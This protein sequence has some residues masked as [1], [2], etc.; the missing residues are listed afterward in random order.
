MRIGLFG[1]TFNPVHIGHLRTVIEVKEQFSLNRIYIVPS[2]IP[3]HKSFAGIASPSDRIEM[4]RLSVC[5]DP[6]FEVSDV[7]LIRGGTS[8]T[9]DTLR[10]FTEKLSGKDESFFIMG[11]DAFLEIHTWKSFRDIFK[12]MPLI[13]MGRPGTNNRVSLDD[14][15]LAVTCYLSFHHLSGYEYIHEHF[16][17]IHPQ[18]QSVYLMGVTPIDISSSKI[19]DLASK[20]RSIRFL[21]PEAVFQ[22]ISTRG[23]YQ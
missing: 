1:G 17:F 10:F 21:V 14:M 4:I 22:Y 7:E 20:G 9:I 13:V 5:D 6:G 16:K 11:I 18:L 2:F 8:Y 23:L 12:I 15:K 3:P 19:R